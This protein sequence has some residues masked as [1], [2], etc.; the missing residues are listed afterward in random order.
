MGIIERYYASQADIANS[1]PP[2]GTTCWICLGGEHIHS[3]SGEMTLMRGCACRGTAGYAHL[4]CLLEAAAKEVEINDENGDPEDL[5]FSTDE[6]WMTC[7]LC[8]QQRTGC[9]QMMLALNRW[10]TA[11]GLAPTFAEHK[12]ARQQLISAYVDDNENEK[13]IEL[14]EPALKCDKETIKEAIN[15]SSDVPVYMIENVISE[16]TNLGMC[17]GKIGRFDE[18]MAHYKEA[19]ELAD[20]VPNPGKDLQLARAT[21]MNNIAQVHIMSNHDPF[22]AIPILEEVQQIRQDLTGKDSFEYLISVFATACAYAAGDRSDDAYQLI[23]DNLPRA[24]RLF[25]QD[26]PQTMRFESLHKSLTSKFGNRRIHAL[27]KGLSNKPE[28]NGTKV[29]VIRYRADKEKYEVINSASNKFLAKPDNLLFDEGTRVLIQGL[30]SASQHNG[31]YGVVHKF[32]SGTGRYIVSLKETG[33]SLLVKP[34]NC[35]AFS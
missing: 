1:I 35:I 5:V 10:E 28:L 9:L 19:L 24:R 4:S 11:K 3:E 18:A 32:N 17:L 13:A 2:S 16:S 29:V 21:T 30:V 8:N 27:L 25:G 7:K 12:N 34:T 15:T 26:H 33:S 6:L 14:I 31:K 20:Q 23:N 22:T